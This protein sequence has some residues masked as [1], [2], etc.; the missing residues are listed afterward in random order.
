MKKIPLTQ[1]KVALVDD[2][3]YVWLSRWKWHAH[4]SD[5]KYYAVHAWWHSKAVRGTVLMHR[6]LVPNAVKLDHRDRDGLNNQRAN[7]RICNDSQNSQNNFGRGDRRLP[8]KGVSI[9]KDRHL[10]VASITKDGKRVYACG[11][12]TPQEAAIAYDAM[13]TNLFGEF[14]CT[15][16]MLGL[17]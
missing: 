13:A 14:A 10:Y 4:W 3:D 17:V 6:V 16:A 9:A 5:G 11:F 7:L 15:N 8:F 12:A 1:G 2:A